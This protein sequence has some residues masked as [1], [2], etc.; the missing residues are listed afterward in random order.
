MH[1][2][3]NYTNAMTWKY[4]HHANKMAWKI[5]DLNKEDLHDLK[6]LKDWWNQF[7]YVNDVRSV[8]NSKTEG[9]TSNRQKTKLAL[10]DNFEIRPYQQE[11]WLALRNNRY[12]LTPV[13]KEL[14][15]PMQQPLALAV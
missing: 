7:E 14:P 3:S 8:L 12:S 10:R 4:D 13:K 2:N 15:M 5:R 1:N 11:V 6:R 9:M